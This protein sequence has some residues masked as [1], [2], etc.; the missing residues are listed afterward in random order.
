[1]PKTD[2]VEVPDVSFPEE[3]AAD[4]GVAEGERQGEGQGQGEGEGEGAPERRRR[5]PTALWVVPVF[6][7]ATALVALYYWPGQ[8]D[9]DTIDAID[10]ASSGHYNDLH[11]PLLSALWRVPYM[12]GVTSPGWVMAATVFTLLLGLYL[13][14]RVRFGPIVSTV[15]ALVCLAWPPVLSWGIHVGRDTWF[16]A[17][18]L[19]AF[20]FAARLVRMGRPQRWFN[21]VASLACAFLCAASWQIALVP[22]AVLFV[23]LAAHLLPRMR[24]RRLVAVGAAV[25][26]C[27]AVYGVQQGLLAALHTASKYPQQSTY[28][29]DLAQL[30]KAEHKDLIPPQ[31]RVKGRP[32]FAVIENEVKVGTYDPLVF[33]PGRVILFGLDA[34]QESILQHAWTTAVTGDLGGYLKERADLLWAQLAITEPSF[35]TWQS[36]PDPRGYQPLDGGLHADGLQWLE[37]FSAGGNLRGDAMYDVWAYLLVS[38][39]SIPYLLWRRR[40]ADGV[41]AALGVAM[42]VFTVALFFTTPAL[43]YRFAYPIVVV[44]T[45]TLPVLVPR[46][47]GARRGDEGEPARHED[48]DAEATVSA[49]EEAP[50]PPPAPVAEALPAA[51]VD[52]G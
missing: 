46:R 1:V 31:L 20:G 42:L 35:W 9:P 52:A 17:L 21:L 4:R 51:P 2:A 26:T 32:T 27:L 37:N 10:Q 38:T 33:G 19:A 3:P 6:C 24:G 12:L 41:V 25:V 44:G 47:R 11:S 7:G 23:V 18:L 14:L 36:H 28:V 50:A 29:Y 43:L 30:S 15:V 8:L 16:V 48:A 5:V 13:V 49:G 22:L 40:G 34:R 45:V 39:L